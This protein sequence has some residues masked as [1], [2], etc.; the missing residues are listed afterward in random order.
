MMDN[1][2]AARICGEIQTGQATD[3][4]V[5][6]LADYCTAGLQALIEGGVLIEAE[7]QQLLATTAL[8]LTTLTVR[9]CQRPHHVVF[10][11][12]PGFERIDTRSKTAAA[13]MVGLQL[14]DAG[15]LEGLRRSLHEAIQHVLTE[16]NTKAPYLTAVVQQIFSGP[17]P[18]LVGLDMLADALE[19]EAGEMGI[20]ARAVRRRIREETRGVVAEERRA[21]LVD[22]GG[23]PL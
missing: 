3:D 21:G 8:M 13:A 7:R 18:A 1:E 15:N 4:D 6:D 16:A 12:P 2:R 11:M 10:G 20:D 19:D 9:Y 5:T 17:L 14:A 23:N 22:A